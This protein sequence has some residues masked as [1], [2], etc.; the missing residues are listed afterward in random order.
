LQDLSEEDE[1][2]DIVKEKS[3]GSDHVH[4]K[5]FSL[6]KHQKQIAKIK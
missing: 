6:A 4:M 5:S 2:P 3:G 1:S